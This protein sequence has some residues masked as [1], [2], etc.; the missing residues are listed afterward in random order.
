MII[1]GTVRPGK[2]LNT[3]WTKGFIDV[4]RKAVAGEKLLPGT[5]N[6][7]LTDFYRVRADFRHA[8]MRFQH[9]WIQGQHCFIM[10]Q[11]HFDN[12]AEQMYLTLEI[13]STVYL[14][15]TLSLVDDQTVDIEIEPRDRQ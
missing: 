4:I 1:T 5:L 9:C 8:D 13:M 2:G 3:D 15:E 12:E 6:V 11:D 7:L 10:R 14:R